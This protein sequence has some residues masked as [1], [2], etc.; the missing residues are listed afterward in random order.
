M[1][2]EIITFGDIEVGTHKFYQRKSHIS[3]YDVNTDKAV[4]SIEVPFGKRKC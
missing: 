2:K 3:I 1:G 4:V